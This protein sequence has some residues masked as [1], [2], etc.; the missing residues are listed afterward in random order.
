MFCAVRKWQN[1]PLPHSS[2][3]SC[4]FHPSASQPR[5]TKLKLSILVSAFNCKANKNSKLKPTFQ[6]GCK[7]KC[8][9]KHKPNTPHWAQEERQ[10]NKGCNIPR[11][12]AFIRIHIPV[13]LVKGTLQFFPSP[14]LPRK[15]KLL[16]QASLIESLLYAYYMS[17]P[18]ANV[19]RT[20]YT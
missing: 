12:W 20:Y 18:A 13:F 2:Y 8:F 11:K 9:M 6:R 3:Y 7:Q 10:H 5:N 4:R 1:H 19:E 14:M 16:E 17:F 15:K